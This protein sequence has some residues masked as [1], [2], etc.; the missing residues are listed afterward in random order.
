M[1]NTSTPAYSQKPLAYRGVRS[2]KDSETDRALFFGREDEAQRLFHLVTSNRLS[3]LCARSGNGKTSLINTCLKDSLRKAG[4]SPIMVRPVQLRSG[5]VGHTL[6]SEVRRQAEEAGITKVSLSPAA[7]IWES[8]L[9]ATFESVAGKKSVPVLI[10]DQFEELFT[11]LEGDSQSDLT[12]EL[13]YLAMGRAPEPLLARFSQLV[14][15]EN[16]KTHPDYDLACRVLYQNGAPDIRIL[17]S[18]REDFLPEIE[19]L[20]TEIPSIFSNIMRLEMLS[21][22][23]AEQAIVKPAL[24][25]GIE[26]GPFEYEPA[27]LQTLLDFFTAEASSKRTAKSNQIEPVHLQIVC[28]RLDELRRRHSSNTIRIRDIGGIEGLKRLLENYYLQVISALPRIRLG[29]SRCTW[30]ISSSNLLLAHRPRYLARDLCECRL[31]SPSGYRECVSEETV[32]RNCG[33]KEA[34]VDKL[35]GERLL[36]RE[37][38]LGRS[39]YELRH[40]ALVAP[41]RDIG[42]RRRRLT[43][44]RRVLFLLALCSAGIWYYPTVYRWYDERLLHSSH[45]DVKTRVEELKRLL[46]SGYR[47]FQDVNL[48]GAKLADANLTGIVLTNC[49][50]QNADL[51]EAILSGAVLSYCNLKNVDLWSANLTSVQVKNVTFD[52]AQLERAMMQNAQVKNCTFRGADLSHAY[53]RKANLTDC[54]FSGANLSEAFFS[55]AEVED[56][57]TFR[58]ADF[59][60]ANFTQAKIAVESN[61]FSETPWWLAA[62]IPEE[63]LLGLIKKYPVSDYIKSASYQRRVINETLALNRKSGEALAL[64]HGKLASI[65]ATAGG[66][67]DLALKHIDKALNIQWNSNRLT[68]KAYILLRRNAPGDDVAARGLLEEACG[69]GDPVT[70]G[71]SKEAVVPSGEAW[72]HLALVYEAVGN[73]NARDTFCQAKKLDYV[74]TYELVLTPPKCRDYYEDCQNEQPKKSESLN[75]VHEDMRKGETEL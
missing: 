21:R 22:E 16:A 13:A 51:Q 33:L 53:A 44:L 52:E 12:Q 11:V 58:N 74:P 14:E 4:F 5:S 32:A 63:A 17:L 69:F 42:T 6:L 18:I 39:H 50:L 49:D 57:N 31:I 9:T 37:Q 45:V 72:F 62:R 23:S 70:L 19:S 30:R 65:I 41:I 46:R 10:L 47:K 43:A 7:S 59:S 28:S 34:D 25:P 24:S 26:G 38:R 48:V 66:D 3:V 1:D 67:A 73:G 60:L 71:Q 68:I 64:A 56:G 75:R 20:K 2:F 8:L 35:C 40:D 61:D 36:S 27:A 54:D 29:W 55:G 15:R